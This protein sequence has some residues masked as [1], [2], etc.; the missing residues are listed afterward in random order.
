[1][2]NRNKYWKASVE[3]KILFFLICRSH[4]LGIGK[5]IH[6]YIVYLAAEEPVIYPGTIVLKATQV[7]Q[8]LNS[9]RGS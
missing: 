5:C 8:L 6:M 3:I 9:S 2:D 4:L 7:P 1:M